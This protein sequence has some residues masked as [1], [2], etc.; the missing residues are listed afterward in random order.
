MAAVDF[1]IPGGPDNSTLAPG[2]PLQME[3][4][5]FHH[6]NLVPV[7]QPPHQFALVSELPTISLILCG[8]YLS[9][10]EM[11]IITIRETT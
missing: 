2:Y 6:V 7:I 11:L 1:P 9:T 10:H 3:L 8:L 4:F 5:G